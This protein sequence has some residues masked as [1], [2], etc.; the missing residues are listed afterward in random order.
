ML[1]GDVALRVRQ[2]VRQTCAI[3]ESKSLP[4]VVSKDP[5]HLLVSAL[6]TMAPSESRRRSKGRPASQLCAAF[7]MLKKRSGGRHLWGRGSLCA[8]VGQRTAEMIHAYRAPHFEPARADNCRTESSPRVLDP[9]ADFQSI[10]LTHQL[11]LVVVQYQT[12]P[13]GPLLG[14][15]ESK[16]WPVSGRHR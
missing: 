16:G 5:V 15:D 14:A 4:G 8:T 2:L 13:G 6:P 10:R 12:L 1:T 11:K 9:S 7:P 3:C